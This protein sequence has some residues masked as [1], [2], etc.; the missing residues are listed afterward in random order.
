M[1][2][3]ADATE[4]ETIA[5]RKLSYGTCQAP[6]TESYLRTS[7]AM[8]MYMTKAALGWFLYAPPS[9]W[10]RVTRWTFP[11]LFSRSSAFVLF[12]FGGM[13]PQQNGRQLR[14]TNVA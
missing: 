14:S 9:Q 4:V 3:F 11:P 12:R 1:S 8:V 6:S 5:N 13:I 10:L 7:T 2:K